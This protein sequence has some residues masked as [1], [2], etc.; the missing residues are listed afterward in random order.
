[1]N[2]GQEFKWWYFS[3][4]CRASATHKLGLHDIVES[5]F[6]KLQHGGYNGK[7]Q[8]VAANVTFTILYVYVFKLRLGY[9][10]AQGKDWYSI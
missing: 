3:L 7:N 4:A 10:N 6:R 1:M 8:I 2:L 9:S 5:S